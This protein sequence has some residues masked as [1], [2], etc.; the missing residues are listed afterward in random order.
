MMKKILCLLIPFNWIFICSAA[1]YGPPYEIKARKSL[2]KFGVELAKQQQ[3]CFLNSGSVEQLIGSKN[4]KWGLS[5]M[6]RQKLTLEEARPLANSIA[7]AL[8]YQLHHNPVYATCL[9]KSAGDNQR[10]STELKDEYMGYRLA[11]W[12]ENMDRPLRP[13]IAQIRLADEKLYYHYA[14]PETQ[15]LQEPIIEMLQVK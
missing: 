4:C 12:D 10:K 3:I 13:Y 2:D 7:N 6:S 9:I 11:F 8:L 1:Y 14:D 15:A 5:L